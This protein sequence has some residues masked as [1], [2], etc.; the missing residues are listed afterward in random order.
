MSG[1]RPERTKAL[2][3]LTSFRRSDP[4]HVNWVAMPQFFRQH[5]Y[6][7]SS[8]EVFHDGMDDP[9]SWSHPSNQTQWVTCQSG[10]VEP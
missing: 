3:F 1:R 4:A 2:N 10:D 6:F 7:T 5:G 9:A 8:A